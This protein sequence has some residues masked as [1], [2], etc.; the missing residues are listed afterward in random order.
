MET[1]FK[2][3]ES[4]INGL[5]SKHKFF[6]TAKKLRIEYYS[7]IQDRIENLPV[8][9]IEGFDFNI[10]VLNLAFD[11]E[12]LHFIKTKLWSLISIEA[13]AYAPE[14]N[15]LFVNGLEIKAP[16]VNSME[17]AVKFLCNNWSLESLKQLK[18]LKAN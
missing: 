1:N 7:D 12:K 3:I 8:D 2:L 14:L 13:H 6:N 11:L 16:K 10:E 4:K 5:N 15:K 18:K 17:T 9:R